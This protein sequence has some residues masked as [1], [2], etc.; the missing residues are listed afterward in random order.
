MTERLR[1]LL[2]QRATAW[3][4]VQDIRT[5][6]E[7]AGRDPSTEENETYERGLADVER[8]SQDIEREER[9]ERQRGLVDDI[10]PEDRSTPPRTE[11]EQRDGLAE[12]RTA[13][14][15]Y[16]RGGLGRLNGEQQQLMERGFVDGSEL[17]AQGAGIDAAG[18]YTVPEDFL[19]RMTEALK[20]FG[21]ILSVVEIL[22]TSTG[23]PVNWP[24]S[25][26]TNAKGAILDEN[27]QVT[28][29]DMSFGQ[30]AL[31]A[32]TYT[33]KMV[34][35]SLQLLQD[36]AFNLDTW[37][38]RKLGERIGRASAEH[39]ALGDGV[40]K[41]QGLFTGLGVGATTAAN[42]KIDFDALI[43][44]EHSVDPA[45]RQSGRAR[46]VLSD[47]ALAALRKTKDGDGR[48]L[49]Q[50]ALTGGIPSTINGHPYTVDNDIAPFAA[51]SRSIAF[52]DFQEAYI[53]RVVAGAQ[54]MRLTERYADF[55]QV[56]FL[57]FQR[58]DGKVNNAAAAKVLATAA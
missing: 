36:S 14:A 58:L 20:T 16:L 38:P 15:Q 12:Y 39:F 26:E 4:Q 43:D 2:E 6:L 34:R 57:G 23:N 29:Q 40:N 31:R 48:Y 8:L 28:E 32:Y 53:A 35:V 44:L 24:T 49:W 54:T 52:G 56:G 19:Q 45:Y 30:T 9:A 41:P 33:S 42:N 13:F 10:R 3:N 1:R 17:R 50:P 27:T 7:R 25:D 47:T 11:E 37:L 18:G 51:A 5:R 55:L 22:N 21:G 46:Y